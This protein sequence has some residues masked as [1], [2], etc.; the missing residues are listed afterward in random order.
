MFHTWTPQSSKIR[1]SYAVPAIHI[2]NEFGLGKG[3]E[4]DQKPLSQVQRNQ[5]EKTPK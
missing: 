3:G 4:K 2:M 1:I 5:R